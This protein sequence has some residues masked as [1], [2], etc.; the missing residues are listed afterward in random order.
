MTHATIDRTPGSAVAYTAVYRSGA[1]LQVAAAPDD[2]AAVRDAVR[3]GQAGDFVSVGLHEPDADTM[4]S[5]AKIFGLHRL[6]V[7]DSLGHAERPKLEKYGDMVLLVMRTLAYVK[8]ADSVAT[9]QVALF[10]GPDYV[11]TVRQGAHF[12]ME[13]VRREIE[14]HVDVLKEGPAAIVYA[15]SDRV[16]DVYEEVVSQLDGD[17]DDVSDAVFATGAADASL[18][19]H[20]LNGEVT[21]L[22]R[23]IRPVASPIHQFAHGEIDGVSAKAQPFFRDVADHLARVADAV[24]AIDNRLSSAFDANMSRIGVQQ[25]DDMRRMSAWA[26]IAAAVTVLAGIYGMNFSHMPELDWRFGYAWGLLLMV[27]SSV[28]LYRQFKKSGWL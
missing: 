22:R 11:V 9:G 23:A 26:A 15:V 12:E 10:M 7:E 21:T 4:R 20:Q 6:A 16:V 19:I 24:E 2:L 17:V 28:V 14:K 8:G 25:N 13:S 18:R 5:V 3:K 1:K 27:L